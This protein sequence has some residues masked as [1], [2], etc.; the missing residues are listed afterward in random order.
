MFGSNLARTI[1]ARVY[2]RTALIIVV[3]LGVGAGCGSKT[4]TASSTS[5]TSTPATTTSTAPATT[6]TIASTTTTI[7]VLDARISVNPP[8]VAPSA[9]PVSCTFAG[10][11]TGGL[12]PFTFRWRFTNPANNQVVDVNDQNARPVL[13]CGFSTGVVTFNL[14]AALTV[15]DSSGTTNTDTANQ[16]I[17]REAGAC[18]T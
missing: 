10:S 4:P 6:T 7:G 3:V 11:A 1:A 13:G 15:T 14:Q 9:G 16:Q 8:C 17:A 18:G 12:T 5:T 2:G